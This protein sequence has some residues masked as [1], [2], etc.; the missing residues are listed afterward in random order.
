MRRTVLVRPCCRGSSGD[1]E[2]AAAEGEPLLVGSGKG[3]PKKSLNTT[4]PGLLCKT[5]EESVARQNSEIFT[6]VSLTDS[7]HQSP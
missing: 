5:K 6:P 4:A 2:T 7:Y 1:R 3:G